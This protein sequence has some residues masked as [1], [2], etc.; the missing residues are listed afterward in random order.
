MRRSNWD[1]DAD[2][3][4]VWFGQSEQNVARV[5]RECDVQREVLFLDEADVLLGSRESAQNRPTQAVTAEFLRH[6]ESFE[7]IFVC[8]TNH[9]GQFDPALFRRFEFRLEFLPLDVRQRREL[10]FEVAL[11]WDPASAV[12]PPLAPELLVQLDRLNQAT[13]GDFA[14]VRRRV[15]A[16]GLDMTAAQ[17]VD[18]L[19]IEHRMKPGVSA[20]A[21][22]CV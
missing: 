11:G 16:L 10:F 14:T 15:M 18:E 8:A 21:I 19:E 6:I 22:G 20:P 1:W 5:F 9:C 2:S 17:W 12:E 3:S 7:D 4:R 13:P